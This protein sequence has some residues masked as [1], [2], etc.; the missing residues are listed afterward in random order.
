MDHNDWV[1]DRLK[2]LDPEFE[3]RVNVALARFEKRR[4]RK[5]VA[6]ILA[7]AAM[8]GVCS[9]FFPQPRA[10]AARCVEACESFPEDFHDHIHQLIW[11]VHNFLGVAPPDFALTDDKGEDFRLSDSFGNVVLLNFWATWCQ[12]CKQE[13]PWFAEFQ[14]TYKGDGFT[15]IGVAMDE[16]GWKS[17]RPFMTTLGLNYRVAIGDK[18]FE[19]K[20]ALSTLPQTLLIGRK[21]RVLTRH[22]GITEKAQFEREIVRALWSSMSSSEREQAR[23]RGF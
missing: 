18:T 7:V 21:G 3:P 10:V 15:V 22:V 8:V 17:V 2:K 23:A 13:A 4:Q 20:Y 19:Q 6:R 11:S 16:D 1:D 12:P 9:L 5:P 14:R